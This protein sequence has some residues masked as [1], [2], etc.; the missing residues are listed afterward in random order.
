LFIDGGLLY[1]GGGLHGVVDD[2]HRHPFETNAVH[3]TNTLVAPRG[4]TII[5]VLKGTARRL[6]SA[7]AAALT[8]HQSTRSWY[9]TGVPFR[10]RASSYLPSMSRPSACFVRRGFLATPRFFDSSCPLLRSP[11]RTIR[12]MFPPSACR[13]H[14]G[15]RVGGLATG[16]AS[17]GRLR[18]GGQVKWSRGSGV[19][20]QVRG[21]RQEGSTLCVGCVCVCVHKVRSQRPATCSHTSSLTSSIPSAVA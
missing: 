7:L 11:S 10:V 13:P 18:V 4:G 15:S 19:R 5:L 16:H 3:P 1:M 8:V 20:G 6:P 14:S 9:L 17:E 21:Q 2:T 12:I